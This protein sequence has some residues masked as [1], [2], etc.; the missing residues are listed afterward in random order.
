M[1][2]DGEHPTFGHLFLSLKAAV[3]HNHKLGNIKQENF[4]LSW[5]WRPE[6]QNQ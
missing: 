6:V 4:I 5:F 1:S 3:V 2:S